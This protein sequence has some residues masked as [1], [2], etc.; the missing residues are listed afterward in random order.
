[1]EFSCCVSVCHLNSAGTP[2]R[3]ANCHRVLRF[4]CAHLIAHFPKCFNLCDCGLLFAVFAFRVPSSL[5]FTYA[6][7]STFLSF[8][9][10]LL[11][12]C[13]SGPPHANPKADS[14][15]LPVKRLPSLGRW[16]LASWF[17][18]FSTGG[19]NKDLVNTKVRNGCLNI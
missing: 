18:N 6:A 2:W 4:F 9:S 3:Q 13:F 12:C 5:P 10:C 17:V 19:K 16:L 8:S 1:M 15:G 7:L 14:A 11:L